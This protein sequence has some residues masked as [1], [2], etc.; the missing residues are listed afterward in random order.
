MSFFVYK[1]CNMIWWEDKWR[2]C[3]VIVLRLLLGYDIGF[4]LEIWVV[5]ILFGVIYKVVDLK[6]F[7]FGKLFMWLVKV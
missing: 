7:R 3:V 5:I 1:G 4:I 6:D 2:V